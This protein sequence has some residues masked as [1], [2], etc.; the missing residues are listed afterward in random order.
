MRLELALVTLMILDMIASLV[1]VLM[2][3]MFHDL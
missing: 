2:F 3:H 1:H